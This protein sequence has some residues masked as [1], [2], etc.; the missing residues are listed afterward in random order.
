MSV[1]NQTNFPIEKLFL[2]CLFFKI[3][4]QG[5]T[6]TE[7]IAIYTIILYILFPSRLHDILKIQPL[8]SDCKE[9]IC[10]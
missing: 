5:L 1:Y 3:Y 6:W 9:I 10:P 7:I 2:T 4:A 8:S